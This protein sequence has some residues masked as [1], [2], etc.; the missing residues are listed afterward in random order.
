MTKTFV[1]DAHK[2]Q[3]DLGIMHAI[4]RAET[5][6][7]PTGEPQ[8]PRELPSNCRRVEVTI[9]IRDTPISPAD[10]A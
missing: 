8:E 7:S 6:L 5:I 2:D 4:A 10:R 3:N 9:S 1:H